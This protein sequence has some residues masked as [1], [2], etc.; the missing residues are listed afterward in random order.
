MRTRIALAVVAVL[1]MGACTTGS[2]PGGDSPQPPPNGSST[3]AP[4]PTTTVDGEPLPDCRS[5]LRFDAAQTVA[6]T[7]EGHVWALDPSDGELSCLWP[8]TDPGPFLWG[9]LGDRVLLGG[10]EVVGGK[11][12]LPHSAGDIEPTIADWGHPVGIAIVFAQQGADRPEKL[13]LDDGEIQT[14]DRMPRGTYLDVAYHPSGLALA[15]VLERKGQQ[16]IWLSSNE[17]KDPRRLV[18]SKS[19]AV[20]TDLEFSS[21]GQS[22]FWTAHH[23][24]GYSQVHSID[25]SHPGELLDGWRSIGDVFVRD[26]ALAPSGSGIAVDAGDSCEASQAL[27]LRGLTKDRPAIPDEQ[28]PTSVLGWLDP[29]TL[30]VGAGGCGSPLDLFAVDTRQGG[31]P[32]PLVA[33]VED[34]ASRAPAPTAPTQLPQI[35][36]EEVPPGGVG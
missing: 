29:R 14:L 13:L 12:A 9:P 32:T 1:S 21:D 19:G 17:G 33:G 3:S 24:Q 18:F 30:L 20:F 25:L 26:L 2:T 36:D 27:I 4:P 6:F 15:F 31:T 16:S 34:A 11:E 7:A 10:L 8:V 23:P 5:R 35:L 28:R 22:L